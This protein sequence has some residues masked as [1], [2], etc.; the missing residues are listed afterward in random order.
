MTPDH[1]ITR[2]PFHPIILYALTF[3]T[4]YAFVISLR[5]QDSMAYLIGP[6]LIVGLFAGLGLLWLVQ[7]GTRINTD[8]RG[9]SPSRLRASAL[10]FAIVLAFLA[11]PIWQLWQNGPRISLRDYNE[12][13]EVIEAVEHWAEEQETGAVLLSDWER[14]TPLWYERY[15]N[16]NWPDPAIVTPKLVAAGTE[17]PWLTAVFDNLAG[18]VYLSNYRPGPLAGTEFRQRLRRQRLPS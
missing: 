12:G 1:L 18:P 3:L 17:N 14:M 7:L 10:N 9:I 5:A 4:I 2:S 15:V 6:F 13:Q 8:A 11:G 16:D